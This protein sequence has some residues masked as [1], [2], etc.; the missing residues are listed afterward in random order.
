MGVL[1]YIERS[2]IL[3]FGGVVVIVDAR[4]VC[5]REGPTASRFASEIVLCV[6]I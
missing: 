3:V 2:E 6:L 5:V 1:A 4:C